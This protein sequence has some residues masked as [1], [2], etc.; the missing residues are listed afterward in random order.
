[1]SW[2]TSLSS[3]FSVQEPFWSL[4]LYFPCYLWFTHIPH[5][6]LQNSGGK[7][8]LCIQLTDFLKF[9]EANYNLNLAYVQLFIGLYW[10]IWKSISLT[11]V[12]KH[13]IYT[14]FRVNTWA[15]SYKNAISLGQK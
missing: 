10:L 11:Y 12:L 2:L 14:V 6:E 7:K 15:C 4:L 1:M 8:F 5:C 3:E 13:N 9:V